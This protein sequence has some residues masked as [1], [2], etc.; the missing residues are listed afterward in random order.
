[1]KFI[2]TIFDD[3]VAEFPNVAEGS[4]VVAEVA[5]TSGNSAT[6]SGD[7]VSSQTTR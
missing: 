2:S 1:M 7:G 4:E 5:K 6:T 3:S